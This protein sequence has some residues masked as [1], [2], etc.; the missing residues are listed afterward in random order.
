MWSFKQKFSGLLGNIFS[1]LKFILVK[2]IRFFL[3]VFISLRNSLLY[4]NI[5]VT[6]R[7]KKHLHIKMKF[8]IPK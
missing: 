3:L 4:S 2:Y 5:Y 1:K 7:K 8:F 6:K